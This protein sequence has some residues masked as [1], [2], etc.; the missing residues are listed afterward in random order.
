[1]RKTI[2]SAGVALAF[3]SGSGLPW[4]TSSVWAAKADQASQASSNL[5]SLIDRGVYWFERFRYDL[6]TQAFNKVLLAQPNNPEA[7]KWK[8]LIDLNSGNS[9][10]A[11]IWLEQLTQTSGP[12][13]PQ[14]VELRQSIE[15]ATS[16]RQKVAELEFLANKGAPADQWLPQLN[17][18][19]KE[20][21]LGEAAVL[22]YTLLSELGEESK[23]LARQ[24]IRGLIARFPRDRRYLK[25]LSDL[26]GTLNQEQDAPVIVE[27]S[28]PPPVAASPAPRGPIGRRVPA[29]APQAEA[30]AQAPAA[31]EEP[32]LNNFEQGS[33]L[34]DEAQA[35]IQSNQT[36]QAIDKLQKAIELNPN[37]AWFRYDL[38]TLLDDQ[39]TPADE[40]RARMIMA[41][42]LELAPEDPDMIFA[43]ALLAS[44]Q[45][46]TDLALARLEKIPKDRWSSGMS[47]MDQRLRYGRYLDNLQAKRQAGRY[48]DMPAVMAQNRQYNAEPAV[49][50]LIMELRNRKTPKLEASWQKN[51]IEGD[52]GVSEIE[53]RELAVQYTL[54][55]DYESQVFFRGD[56][57]EA[58]AGDYTLTE[59]FGDL[60]DFGTLGTNTT[61]ELQAAQ[62]NPALLPPEFLPNKQQNYRGHLLGIGWQN[63]VWRVDIGKPVGNFPV[64]SWVGGI[65]WRTDVGDSTVRVDF[66]RRIVGGSVLSSVGAIDPGTGR[67]WGGA[68]RNGVTG[69]IYT[70]IQDDAAFVGIG[71]VNYITGKELPTNRELNL[72]LILS[73]TVWGNEFQSVDLGISGFFWR[74]QRNMRLYTFG[75]GGYYSPQSFRSVSF[76][77]TWTGSKN[78]WSWRLQAS[79]G[80]SRSRENPTELYPRQ[81]E[82]RA[83]VAAAGNDVVDE[84]GFGGGDSYGFT[85]ALERRVSEKFVIGLRGAI[86]RSEGY[87]PDSLLFYMRYFFEGRAPLLVPPEGLSP[88]SQF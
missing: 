9:N 33:E 17:A 1:M 46:D 13:H 64:D 63:D 84:G 71:R 12:N 22:Y 59:D 15:L 75:Q 37:Y 41:N 14:T 6:S 55:L 52:V 2:L 27:A 43:S 40:A 39:Q 38:A 76:P 73:K 25:L 20:P 28:P 86:D 82:F 61:A 10:T 42:G 35:L 5:A 32:T 44:R 21:P 81:P 30:V 29:P 62:T 53:S 54:P 57:I 11:Q 68:R 47:A 8:G 56:Y 70:P 87:N 66:A 60:T 24:K 58:I 74:F 7:L 85:Y 19:F 45:G 77:I 4:V 69:L 36:D 88:Y 80:E 3:V 79:A 50:E 72:Q 78:N 83:R 31:P 16:R 65:Q 49:R 48:N 67:T 18:L 23:Q 51:K 34:A 26:G